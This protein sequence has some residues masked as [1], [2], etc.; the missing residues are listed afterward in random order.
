MPILIQ[1]AV[2][3]K[4]YEEKLNPETFEE[5]LAL[6]PTKD[7]KYGRWI[8]ENYLRQ[9]STIDRDKKELETFINEHIYSSIKN[10]DPITQTQLENKKR[11]MEEEFRLTHGRNIA[12]WKRFWEEDSEKVTENLITY[13]KLKNK[14][15]LEDE[16]LYNILN[17]KSF[18]A[19]WELVNKYELPVD[20]TLDPSE[21]EKWYQGEGW[22]VVIPKTHKASCKYG[23][24]TQ[25]C[26]TSRDSD[27][28]F[29][30]YSS[31]G[32]LIII[33]DPAGDKWQLH[34][35]SN[36]W[37]DAKDNEIED[38]KEFIADLP[39]PV[40]DAIFKHTYHLLF[41]DNKKEILEKITTQ[42]PA[43]IKEIQKLANRESGSELVSNNDLSDGITD[44]IPDRFLNFAIND[45]S[46]DLFYGL[47][48]AY[49]EGYDSPWY[50][51]DEDPENPD[52]IEVD[53]T[54][55][56]WKH[57]IDLWSE[58]QR[59]QAGNK[60]RDGAEEDLI[61]NLKIDLR[62][63]SVDRSI[64]DI[65]YETA[66]TY[67][68]DFSFYKDEIIEFILNLVAYAPDFSDRVSLIVK[69]EM[70]GT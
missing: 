50:Y 2:N 24:N 61:K 69:R 54:N 22:T 21:Y 45:N 16:R 25:W 19:L 4:Y 15:M 23:A 62:Y 48:S 49:D 56:H 42:S 20:F 36:Q 52:D 33:I 44:I 29:N 14:K 60:R 65:I 68:N 27:R 39:L 59:E 64:V 11:E 58:E 6:D 9:F 57:D 37:M 40:K 8:V 34:F 17:I 43:I 51:L 47:D 46:D 30:R 7:H 3:Y 32:P 26:T 31:E 5:L 55:R 28:Y 18:S 12:S 41:S 13:T 1:E 10:L 53:K 66:V 38:R 67:L 35:E 70:E 63:D